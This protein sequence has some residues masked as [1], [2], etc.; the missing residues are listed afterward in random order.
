M[1]GKSL[2]GRHYDRKYGNRDTKKFRTDDPFAEFY[3]EIG[4]FSIIF[5]SCGIL[6]NFTVVGVSK[7]HQQPRF[8]PLGKAC[9]FALE[10]G[11]SR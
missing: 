10:I 5:A 8:A 9:D 4:Y 3:A 1:L 2:E 11:E 7:A 6:S